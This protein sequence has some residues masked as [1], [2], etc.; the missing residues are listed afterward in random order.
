[1]PGFCIGFFCMVAFPVSA[2]MFGILFLSAAHHPGSFQAWINPGPQV[3]GWYWVFFGLSCLGAAVWF[4][5]V[6]NQEAKRKIPASF[7]ILAQKEQ[8]LEERLRLMEKLP[9]AFP[10][11]PRSRRRL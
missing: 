8:A 1:M 9:K 7:E 3:L 2:S 5:K 6:L 10:A 11:T 4:F